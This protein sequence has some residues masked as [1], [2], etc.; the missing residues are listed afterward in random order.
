MGFLGKNFG[1]RVPS[2]SVLE[3]AQEVGGKL[4]IDGYRR[5]AE[6]Q[7]FAPT[8]DT[9]DQEILE[10][11]SRVGSAFREASKQRDEIIPSGNLNMI[12]FHFLQIKEA[13]GDGFMVEHLEYEIEKYIE[14]GLRESYQNEM[15][16][17]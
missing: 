17:F 9:S 8:K 6:H 11:Y 7:D 5:I 15:D 12:V 10:I 3:A 2:K 13:N 1:K 4:I 16:L 14:S